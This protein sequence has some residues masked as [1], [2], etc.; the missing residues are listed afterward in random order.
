MHGREFDGDRTWVKFSMSSGPRHHRQS[1]SKPVGPRFFKGEP[2][3]GLLTH[4]G[5]ALPYDALAL[6]F[7]GDRGQTLAPTLGVEFVLFD[8][9]RRD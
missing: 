1:R 6:L 2:I 5:A 9:A 4:E 3:L 8:H 7:D